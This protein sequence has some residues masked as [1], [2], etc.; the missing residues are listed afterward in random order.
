[1]IISVCVGLV[2]VSSSRSPGWF[3]SIEVAVKQMDK[4]SMPK[5]GVI[6]QRSEKPLNSGH[7]GKPMPQTYHL[8]MDY[9]IHLWWFRG[10]S[11][12]GFITFSIW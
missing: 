2:W 9:T 7:V 1:M 10:W 11:M 12:I 4:A 8:G 3:V 5:R 6:W